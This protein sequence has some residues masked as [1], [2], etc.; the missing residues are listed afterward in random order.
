MKNVIIGI[1]VGGTN[2]KIGLVSQDGRVISRTFLNTKSFIRDK[3]FLINALIKKIE[4]LIFESRLTRKRILGIGMGLPGLI[5]AA[6]GFVHFLPNIPG[7]RDVPLKKL[8]EQKLNIPAFLDN[9]VNIIA[10][11]EWK[12]GAGRGCNDLICITLGTGVGGGLILNGSLYRGKQFAAGEIGHMP[13][14]EIGPSCNCGGRGCFER[15]VGNS[16]I[17]AKAGKIF[18]KKDIQ[19]EEIFRLA[20]QGNQKAISFWNEVA[21]H[22]GNGLVG[23]VN[24]LNP[25]LIIVGGGV[26]N[27]FRFLYKTINA[28][29][30]KRAMKVQAAAVKVVRA[31]LGDD[32]GII[33]G[34]VLVKEYR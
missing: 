9:D 7:W 31:Q 29:I 18:H 4:D 32:A 33:G 1:D 17:L 28:V 15:C 25:Q 2:I 21:A 16:H 24:L 6:K 13:L 8:I 20:S 23:V 30:K 11:A 26:S 14:N 27:N 19:L 10:L 34:Q 12:F 22:I 3:N 5:D